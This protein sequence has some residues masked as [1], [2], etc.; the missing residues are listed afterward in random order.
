MTFPQHINQIV[1]VEWSPAFSQYADGVVNQG[2]T[3]K[4]CPTWHHRANF[5]MTKKLPD[6]FELKLQKRFNGSKDKFLVAVGH[7]ITSLVT[8]VKISI[9]DITTDGNVKG[10]RKKRM[11][12][13]EG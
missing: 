4:T 2:L 11:P 1:D 6:A 13:A 3:S 9:T 10:S 12:K 7:C 8:S 5:F